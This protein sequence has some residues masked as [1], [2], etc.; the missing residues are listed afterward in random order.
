MFHF[1]LSTT[2]PLPSASPTRSIKADLFVNGEHTAAD[3]LTRTII[4]ELLDEI[5]ILAKPRSSR[6]DPPGTL[7]T[8]RRVAQETEK[9]ICFMA[10]FLRTVSQVERFGILMDRH[11]W[12]DTPCG[13][14]AARTITQ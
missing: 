8:N 11:R 9:Q 2:Q 1:P 12:T 7:K 10:S 14:K 3:D 5:G 4:L 6:R 13:Y